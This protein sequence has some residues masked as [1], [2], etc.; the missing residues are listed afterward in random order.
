MKSDEVELC[1]AREVLPGSASAAVAAAVCWE[2]ALLSSAEITALH[3]TQPEVCLPPLPESYT[4]CHQRIYTQTTR[5]TALTNSKPIK[6]LLRSIYTMNTVCL[7]C[8][9]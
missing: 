4:V 9:R 6:W 3:N 5:S 1:E 7:S 8:N 2:S